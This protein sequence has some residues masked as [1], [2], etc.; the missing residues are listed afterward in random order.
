MFRFIVSDDIVTLLFQNENMEI[1]C[2][3]ETPEGLDSK[4]YVA[5]TV[6]GFFEFSFDDKKIRFSAARYD[7]GE[8]GSLS[9]YV[10]MTTEIKKSLDYALNEWRL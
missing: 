4:S 7:R 10:E 2:C 5:D 1:R 9:I 8:G 3:P 6:D